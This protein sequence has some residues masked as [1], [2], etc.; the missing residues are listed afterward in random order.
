MPIC[1]AARVAVARAREVVI[2]PRACDHGCAR[3][4]RIAM[5]AKVAFLNVRAV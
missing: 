3:A 2:F 5:R 1:V 4:R